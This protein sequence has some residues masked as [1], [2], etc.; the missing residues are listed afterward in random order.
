MATRT[1]AQQKIRRFILTGAIASI[2]MTGAWYGA[3]LKVQSD[4]IK[5]AQKRLEATP[6]ER[7]TQLAE[8]RMELLVKRHGLE[9]KLRQTEARM[10]GATREESMVGQERRRGQ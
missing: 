3:G 5:T 2:T 7:I 8:H 1:P 9:K 10:N 4:I 6:A